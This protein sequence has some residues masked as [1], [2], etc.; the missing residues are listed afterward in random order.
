MKIAIT[1]S[2]TDLNA[3]LDPRFGR[4]AGFLLVD[5][6]TNEI[7]YEPNE[8]NLNAA[9]GAGIQSAQNIA[10]AGVQAV[11]SGHCGPKAYRVLSASG[12][13]V[14]PCSAAT[15][16]EALEQF[17]AGQLKPANGADVEGHW[18]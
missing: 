2:G 4:A 8:Q 13:A 14:Y 1:V 6:K 7:A 18:A 3:A 17:K 11:I 15:A 10:A 16:A 5:T 12:I 9:Q